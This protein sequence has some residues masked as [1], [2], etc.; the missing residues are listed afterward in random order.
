MSNNERIYNNAGRKNDRKKN[1]VHG[2]KT[3]TTMDKQLLQATFKAMEEERKTP[4]SMFD[5]AM[6]QMSATPLESDLKALSGPR[7]PVS[8]YAEQSKDGD[9]KLTS[10]ESDIKRYVRTNIAASRYNARIAD[11]KERQRRQNVE[12]ANPYKGLSIDELKN[13]EETVKMWVSRGEW[14]AEQGSAEIK[15]IEDARYELDRANTT[16]S[17]AV[18][19]IEGRS[20]EYEG[21]LE[22]ARSELDAL[23]SEYAGAVKEAARNKKTVSRSYYNEY[24]RKKN[25]LNAEIDYC[26]TML[27]KYA[28]LETWYQEKNPYD[29]LSEDELVNRE[30]AV[31]SWVKNGQCTAEQGEAEKYKIRQARLNTS[32]TADDFYGDGAE[33][34]ETKQYWEERLRKAE[35]EKEA[36]YTRT[37]TQEEAD[38]INAEIDLCKTNIAR[39]EQLEEAATERGNEVYRTRFYEGIAIESD[40]G[41]MYHPSVYFAERYDT[42]TELPAKENPSGDYLYNAINTI[43]K[44]EYDAESGDYIYNKGKYE[45]GAYY[46][47]YKFMTDEERTLYNKLYNTDEE[48]GTNY[49]AEYLKSLDKELTGRLNEKEAKEAYEFGEE[50]PFL[51]G[52]ATV[53]TDIVVSP[54]AAA[55]NV[56]EKLVTGKVDVNDGTS[57][58][59]R[60]AQNYRAGGR[61]HMVDN[62]GEWAGVAYDTGLELTN[63][64]V[65]IAV[66]RGVGAGASAL[67]AGAKVAN[68]ASR[69]VSYSTMFGRSA[70]Y[71]MISAADRGAS[72]R[73]IIALGLAT[74]MLEIATEALPF[75]AFMNPR[76]AKNFAGVLMEG[77]KQVPGNAV[78][79]IVAEAGGMMLDALITGEKS[80]AQIEMRRLITEEGLTAEEAAKVIAMDNLQRLG[81]SGFMGAIVGGGAGTVT[82]GAASISYNS[83][84]NSFANDMI[85]NRPDAVKRLVALSEEIK[86]PATIKVAEQIQKN[87]ITAKNVG[88]MIDSVIGQMLVEKGSKANVIRSMYIL[89]GQDAD[90]IT[91]KE[92]SAVADSIIRFAAGKATKSD[93]AVLEQSRSA[94]MVLDVLEANGDAKKAVATL[95]DKT[96]ANVETEHRGKVYSQGKEVIIPEKARIAKNIILDEESSA[97]R[98]KN[99]KGYKVI[100]MMAQ[101]LRK[102]VKFVKGLTDE[103]GNVLDG[104]ITENGIIINTEGKNPV[105]W[106]ATH[107][108]SHRMKQSAEKAWAKYQQYVVKATKK[109]GTYNERFKLK[110]KAYKTT[111]EAYINEEIAADYIGELFDDVDSLADFIRES[112]SDAVG[113]R[114]FWYNILDRLGI[115]GEKRKAQALWSKAYKKAMQSIED[116]KVGEYSG[117]MFSYAGVRA[118][119]ANVGTLN[120]AQKM[121]REG[122]SA[123]E[124][125]RQTGWG[126]GL[127]GKWKFEISDLESHLID[128]SEL[129]T[130]YNS[131]GDYYIGRLGDIF[132]HGKLFKAYPHL[133]ETRI[134]V[135]E[136]NP[137]TQGR[138]SGKRNEIVLSKTL[139]ER[140]TKEYKDLLENRQKYITEIEKTPEYKQYNAVYEMSDN[141]MDAAEWLKLEEK[142][143]NDFFSSDVGQRYYE[144]K[145]GKDN[146]QKYELGWSDKAKEVLLHEVQHLIQ[147]EEGFA[148]GSN[149]SYWKGKNNK[150]RNASDLYENTAGEIEARDVQV[151]SN[152]TEEKRRSAYPESFKMNNKVVFADSE[153]NYDI[154]TLD[155]GKAY[156]EATRQVITGNSISEWRKSITNFFNKALKNGDIKITATDG[157]TLTI[158]KDTAKKARD[159]YKKENGKIVRMIDDEF[160]V[161][162]HAES[163]IDELAEIA[164][165]TGYRKDG[166]NHSFAKNGFDY[167]TV[168]FKDFDNSYYKITLSVGL[169]NGVST[170]YNVGKIKTDN[171]PTGKIISRKVGQSPMANLSVDTT[172]SQD[173]S[174]VNTYSMQ[175]GGN[176]PKKSVTGTRLDDAQEEILRDAKNDSVEEL[177]RENE[178]LK[179]QLENIHI[180]LNQAEGRGP[181]VKEIKKAAQK[182][183]TAYSSKIGVAELH[184]ELTKL[185]TYM[186]GNNV[187]PE[188]VSKR[189]STLAGKVIENA[190]ERIDVGS[191]YTDLL[192]R[193]RTTRILVPES[194][195]ADFKDGYES[196]RKSNMGKLRLANDGMEL[197]VLWDELCYEYP[198]FFSEDV[199]G[200]EER[201][202]R[203]LEIREELRPV[204]ESIFH[205]DEEFKAAQLALENDIMESFYNIPESDGNTK[206]IFYDKRASVAEQKLREREA[207]LYKNIE[208][209]KKRHAAEMEKAQKFAKRQQSLRGRDKIKRKIDSDYNYISRM[210]KNPTDTRHVPE[211]MRAGVSYLLDCFNFETVQLD[212][213][214]DAGKEADSPTAVK[215]AEMHKAYSDI[216]RKAWGIDSSST[217][218]NLL[219]EQL[220]KDLQELRDEIPVNESGEFKR[221]QD[222]SVEELRAVSKVLTG[223]HH[224]ITTKNK[225]FNGAIK[226]G[227]SD[228][229]EK[230]ISDMR[231]TRGL[232]RGSGEKADYE[233]TALE[234]AIKLADNYFNFDNV[235]PWDFFHSIGGTMEKLYG[236]E[237]RAFDRHI[238][239]IK[240]A[241]ERL[242]K[243]TEG[244]NLK[245]LTGKSAEKAWFKL[246]SGEEI[247][248][249][250]GQVLSLYALYQRNQG[251]EHILGGGIVTNS[252]ARNEQGHKASANSVHGV[253]E[254]DLGKMFEMLSK[255]ERNMVSD[256]VD[257][258]SKRCSKWGNET[259]MK[260][261]GYEKYGEGW[262]FPIKVSKQTLATYYGENGEGNLRS[263]GFTKQLAKKAKNAVEIGDFFDIVTSHI[264]GM[265][266]YNTVAIPMLDMERVLNYTESGT[267]TKVRQ[268][269]VKTFGKSAEKYIEAFHKDIN[270]SR[271]TADRDPLLEKMAANAKKASIG[272]NLRVLLQQPTSIARVLLFM[273]PRDIPAVWNGV[274]LKK[275]MQENIPIAYWKSLGFRDIGVGNTMKEVLLDNESLYNKAAMGGYGMADDFTWTLIYG[276]V[277]NEIARKN[278]SL[279]KNGTQFMEKVRER[280][281]YIVDRSQVVDSVFHRTQ[282]MRSGNMYTK[283]ATMFMSEPLKTYNMYRT[284]MLDAVKNGEV[285][286]KAARATAVF[287][288]S[289]LL[290]SLAQA[291]P[292]TW[293]EDD[294]KELFKDGKEI[295]LWDRFFKKYGENMADNS[296]PLTYFPYV[297][298]VWSII[299]GYSQERIEYSNLSDLIAST[300]GL[301]DGKRT[302]IHKLIALAKPASAVLGISAGNLVRDTKALAETVYRMTGDEYADYIIDKFSYNVKNP[303]NKS[304]FMKHYKRAVQNGHSEDAAT[305]LADYMAE[306]FKGHDFKHEHAEDVI[307]EMSKLYGKTDDDSKLFYDLPSNE[308]SFDKGKIVI[309]ESDYPQYVEGTYKMLFDMAYEMIADERYNDLSDEDKARSFG[310]IKSYAQEAQRMEGVEGY[311]LS[312]WKKAVYDGDA[313]YM[314]TVLERKAERDYQEARDVF[315]EDFNYDSAEYSDAEIGVIDRVEN[316]YASYKASIEQGRSYNE[317][318]LRH[319]KVYD[320]KLSEAMS[321]EEYAGHRAEAKKT[322]AMADGKPGLKKDELKAYLDSTEYSKAVKTALFEA[323]GNKGWVNPYTGQKI[324]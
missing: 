46:D 101:D 96:P 118:K 7:K 208:A 249:S 15:K 29:G 192:D 157:S 292:D 5:I 176:Y 197:D 170:V 206:F 94:A 139:F 62:Y 138:A 19:N 10:P 264:N 160:L 45:F 271:K 150:N 209:M 306:T 58:L 180:Q 287:V 156:I 277:K 20:Q 191:E 42:E 133:K 162:L 268:E 122:K 183:R 8:L 71:T 37:V 168:Y 134:I 193:I 321:I 137:G 108:F 131:D 210:V 95:V 2:K 165:K 100:E 284:E 67:G 161:K 232:R 140:K 309:P 261:Y 47:K 187:N 72:D 60:K 302:T 280:F 25:E 242:K 173:T 199:T 315:K 305:I 265:S 257:F 241:A 159:N 259:S 198:H 246:E 281:N 288:V 172:V 245:K 3:P 323:I 111:D 276:A 258:L 294:E 182:I 211:E 66:T 195:R 163:H 55:D 231:D 185:Y 149:P 59:I 63:I 218:S 228:L 36:Y 69:I 147:Y 73:E 204:E 128:N 177:V 28:N 300:K 237:R 104:V 299:Q 311:E 223:I 107:E 322:A 316:D 285:G 127:D 110:A 318:N 154:V 171:L 319:I 6:S 200:S 152:M 262:Y 44:Y 310:E 274:T 102:K 109:D 296:N 43:G 114:N 86:S 174:V 88:N 135:Q 77:L 179:K 293:R 121:E 57:R 267:D 229:G 97:F 85:Q 301:R 123:E 295:P 70:S 112:R 34:G 53:G 248:L 90:F 38:R 214:K 50:H 142:A 56:I 286:K 155:S 279:D 132:N 54:V 115:H 243:A 255:E 65:T 313:K 153:V 220:T 203:I 4:G 124:I 201:L 312:G 9:V 263:Q 169:S 226:D 48:R 278:P 250:K 83:H 252:Q 289:N 93:V 317:S 52:A 40:D 1:A 35:E 269:I 64:A 49:A 80:E 254:I 190:T 239:N 158:T 82:S 130:H 303:G 217:E 213:I 79:E 22:T 84:L 24:S 146:V 32:V 290:L 188:E 33:A 119:T 113:V 17:V 320:E 207:E 272:L 216:M 238:G 270:G 26:K 92:A 215:L 81:S 87:G 68:T 11:K 314:D 227:I 78:E 304:R 99:G 189:I 178:E 164:K 105:K 205:S 116:G 212:K 282:I 14:T 103:D 235:Q 266:L 236:E 143:R 136:M 148:K 16:G 151:R 202:E 307:T 166:K 233:E 181:D 76:V 144:L 324:Q 186:S 219:D 175:D 251:K 89:E 126:R 234:K 256:I 120:D 13:R 39:Y 194:E 308:F 145:W 106:A 230:S 221:I 167:K 275:E 253:T 74:G 41:G 291:L 298:D 125:W 283:T 27:E 98:T 240:E 51:A 75:E 273:N 21:R 117:E 297:K 244:I 260:L 18:A 23:D 196:F 12:K 31:D 184:R 222:M 91:S 30:E 224:V 247:R 129:E 225:A 61:Q 141:D